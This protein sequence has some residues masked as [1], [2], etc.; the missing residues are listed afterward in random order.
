MG[1]FVHVTIIDDVDHLGEEDSGIVL[2]EISLAFES[3]EELIPL[4]I[5]KSHFFYSSTMKK[6]S[7]SSKVS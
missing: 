5:A 1:H 2:G 3:A 7:L 4:A 6:L